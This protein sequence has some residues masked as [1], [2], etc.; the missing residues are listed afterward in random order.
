[1]SRFLLAPAAKSDIFEIW[2]YY[3]AEVGGVELA[4]RMRDEIFS[5]IRAAAR[6]P[7][8]HLCRDLS[9]EQSRFWRVRKYLIIYRS[10]TKPMQVVRVF[11]G[12]RDVQAMLG[13]G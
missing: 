7:D 8:G 5:G 2:N 10:E 9:D 12:A 13:E 1:M 3:A 6:K 11:H 4:D